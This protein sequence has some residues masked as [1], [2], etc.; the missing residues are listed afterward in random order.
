MIGCSHSKYTINGSYCAYYYLLFLTFYET[1]LFPGVSWLF[2]CKYYLPSSY[3]EISDFCSFIRSSALT[4][5]KP[6]LSPPYLWIKFYIYIS[7]FT[8]PIVMNKRLFTTEYHVLA[9]LFF[10]CTRLY[11][12]GSWCFYEFPIFSLTL[13]FLDKQCPREFSAKSE[14]F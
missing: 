7:E 2:S 4:S 3:L 6:H 13:I 5:H 10:S 11:F 1:P 14:M 9:L 8:V 12:S